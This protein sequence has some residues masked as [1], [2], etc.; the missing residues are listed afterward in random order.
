MEEGLSEESVFETGRGR[1]VWPE[2]GKDNSSVGNGPDR[3]GL[4]S[5]SWRGRLRCHWRVE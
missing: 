2:R 1:R 4:E 3:T 5:V